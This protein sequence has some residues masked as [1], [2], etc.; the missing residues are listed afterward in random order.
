M[1]ALRAFMVAV[2]CLG[3]VAA[4]CGSGSESESP[5]QAKA[6]ITAAWE[7]FFDP[8]VPVAQKTNIV[9]NYNSLKPILEAQ[10]NS[11]QA[12]NIKAK[13]KDVTLQ[14]G[15]QAKVDYDILNAQT[16]DSLLASSGAAIKQGSDWKV[17]QQT[18]CSLVKLGDQ[19]AKCP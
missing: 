18:F 1:R 15:G 14:S 6:K 7:K 9:E 3:F 16:G 19:N 10:S 8:S 2:V 13:V 17:S 12:K 4:A 11:P 5:A